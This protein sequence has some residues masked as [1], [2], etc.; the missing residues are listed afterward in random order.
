MQP[1]RPNY[2]FPTTWNIY[3]KSAANLLNTVIYNYE[4]THVALKNQPEILHADAEFGPI[5][6]QWLNI[7]K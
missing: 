6:Q 7:Y 2:L 3:Q 5:T 1:T 4:N